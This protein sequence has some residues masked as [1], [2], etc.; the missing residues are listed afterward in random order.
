ML[1]AQ[2]RSHNVL[3]LLVIHSRRGSACF[4]CSK[5]LSTL[6]MKALQII[7]HKRALI[8]SRQC[9]GKRKKKREHQDAAQ[10]GKIKSASWGPFSRKNVWGPRGSKVDAGIMSRRAL[11]VHI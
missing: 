3:Y 9:N 10:E 4:K 7:L 8:E 2:A 11:W 5:Y 6:T 1:L